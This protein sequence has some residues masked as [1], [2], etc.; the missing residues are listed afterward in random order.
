MTNAAL[1]TLTL[2]TWLQELHAAA[3]WGDAQESQRLLA[4]ADEQYRRLR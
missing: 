2:Q 1:I 4:C 3:S